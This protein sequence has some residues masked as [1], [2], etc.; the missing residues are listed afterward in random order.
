MK[1]LLKAAIV[2]TITANLVVVGVA[3]IGLGAFF[4]NNAQVEQVAE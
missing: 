1:T 3:A 2:A 4:V